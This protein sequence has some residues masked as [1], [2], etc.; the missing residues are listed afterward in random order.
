MPDFL[1]TDM[2]VPHCN[3]FPPVTRVLRDGRQDGTGVQGMGYGAPG[4]AL[5]PTYPQGASG[6]PCRCDFHSVSRRG[7]SWGWLGC[8]CDAWHHKC[9]VHTGCW[10]NHVPLCLSRQASILNSERYSTTEV[11]APLQREQ[12]GGSHLAAPGLTVGEHAR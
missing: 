8:P 11:A 4:P 1:P 12:S 5:T 3:P 10:Y 6:K 2:H 9:P 7:M